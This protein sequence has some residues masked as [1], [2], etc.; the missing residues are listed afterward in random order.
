M[1][2]HR[3]QVLRGEIEA[4][5]HALTT[6]AFKVDDVPPSSPVFS[7]F[8]LLLL[9][10]LCAR[11]CAGCVHTLLRCSGRSAHAHAHTRTRTQ[12]LDTKAKQT[13]L[14]LA[15][16]KGRENIVHLLLD[17]NADAAAGCVR[18]SVRV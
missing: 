15:A 3:S 2:N 18:V 1:T 12:F 9:L 13:A 5:Q 8:F 7:Y 10:L 11:G 14:H 6:Q 17:H 4:V 16:S